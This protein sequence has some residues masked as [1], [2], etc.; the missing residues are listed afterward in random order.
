MIKKL[1]YASL[2]DRKRE[3]IHELAADLAEAIRTSLAGEGHERRLGAADPRGAASG[4]RA[5]IGR[6]DRR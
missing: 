4:E 3:F 2:A 1:G 6:G 5:K